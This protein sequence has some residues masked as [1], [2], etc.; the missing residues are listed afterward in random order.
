[1]LH[2]AMAAMTYDR[3]Q[4]MIARDPRTC[5]WW[6]RLRLLQLY[7]PPTFHFHSTSTFIPFPFPL[8]LPFSPHFP[9]IS[10]HYVMHLSLVDSEGPTYPANAPLTQ[11]DRVCHITLGQQSKPKRSAYQ[12]V[13]LVYLVELLAHSHDIT[14]DEQAYSFTS[15]RSEVATIR[16]ATGG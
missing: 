1:M 13:G 6:L 14:P 12:S 3:S 9:S 5:S 15:K 16:L 11:I 10:A 4:M 2:K 8:P 7:P